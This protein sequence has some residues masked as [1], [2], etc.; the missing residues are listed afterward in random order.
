[1]EAISACRRTEHRF[2][3]HRVGWKG[4][5]VKKRGT[6]SHPSVDLWSR[7]VPRRGATV[8]H[9]EPCRRQNGPD[10]SCWKAKP[11]T[12]PPGMGCKYWQLRKGRGRWIKENRGVKRAVGHTGLPLKKIQTFGK[13]R[14]GQSKEARLGIGSQ[15][16]KSQPMSPRQIPERNTHG[17]AW[18][19]ENSRTKLKRAEEVSLRA[20]WE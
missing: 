9:C 2:S 17:Y 5:L 16:T 8:T 14:R 10:D 12:K 6:L 3:I 1:M 20:V 4:C 19:G 7:S 15:M 18:V 13:S 11:L